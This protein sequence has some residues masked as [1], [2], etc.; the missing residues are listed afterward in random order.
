LS[1]ISIERPGSQ[2]LV[3]IARPERVRDCPG[4]MADAQKLATIWSEPSLVSTTQFLNGNRTTL[5][6]GLTFLGWSYTFLDSGCSPRHEIP[7]TDAA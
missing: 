5:A 6:I 4:R 7:I 1:G 3:K 2:K